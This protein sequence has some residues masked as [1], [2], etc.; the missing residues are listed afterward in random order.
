MVVFKRPCL[1]NQLTISDTLSEVEPVRTV[2][3]LA[4]LPA[5]SVILVSAFGRSVANRRYAYIRYH[6]FGWISVIEIIINLCCPQRSKKPLWPSFSIFRWRPVQ[7][8][9]A[10]CITCATGKILP[11]TGSLSVTQHVRRPA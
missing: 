8:I 9:S 4:S 2:K 11:S 7:L 1:F 3:L 5:W 10:T 6:W